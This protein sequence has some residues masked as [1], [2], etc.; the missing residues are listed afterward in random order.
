MTAEESLESLTRI[1]PGFKGSVFAAEPDVQNPLQMTWDSRGRLWI[2][3]N[4]SYDSDFLVD[5]YNDRI[6]ILEGADGGS[7]FTSRKV[8][9]DDIKRLMG[10][11][12]GHGGVWAIAPPNIL[13]IPDRNSDGVPDGPAE[14]V[15][16][17]FVYEGTNMHTTANSLRFG[18]DGWIYGRT[19]HAH[20]H[21]VGPPGTP[22]AQRTRL[23]GTIYRFHPQTRVFESLMSG[24]VN[25]FGQ[26]WDKHGE[27]FFVSTTVG[28]FWYAMTGA[29][30]RSSSAS[31][32]Q[33]A[34]EL[35]D[36]IGDFTFG[37]AGAGAGPAGPPRRHGDHALA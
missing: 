15:Y 8:F 37:G 18:L 3:E 17:G 23:H 10:F 20:I 26:D 29:K 12:V 5:T 21:M 19:G 11:A 9:A 30:F 7:K 4:Y 14:I 33:K 1:P 27:H 6:V 22:S 35:I 32:N 31:P 16:D 2:S 13:F 28:P 36:Q 24:A 25:T 34:Y